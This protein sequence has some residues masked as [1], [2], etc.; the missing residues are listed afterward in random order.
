MSIEK[1]NKLYRKAVLH[2]FCQ[3]MLRKNKTKRELPCLRVRL[4]IIHA[5]NVSLASF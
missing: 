3:G 5:Y 2:E 1:E 4:V